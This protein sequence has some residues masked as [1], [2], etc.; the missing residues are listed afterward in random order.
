MTDQ[1]IESRTV[2]IK[3]DEVSPMLGNLIKAEEK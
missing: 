1:V 3:L 2:L